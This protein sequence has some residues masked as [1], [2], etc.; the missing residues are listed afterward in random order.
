MAQFQADHS[1][2]FS[3][4]DLPSPAMKR[5]TSFANYRRGWCFGGGEEFSHKTLAAAKNVLSFMENYGLEVEVYPGEDGDIIVSGKFQNTI[6]N[7][8]IQSDLSCSFY[9]EKDGIKSAETLIPYEL[10]FAIISLQTEAW[11]TYASYTHHGIAHA[12]TNFRTARSTHPASREAAEFQWLKSNAPRRTAGMYV[13]TYP[14]FSVN[15]SVF[16]SYI[17]SGAETYCQATR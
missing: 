12:T 10:I 2:F 7:V 11:N 6:L 1:I 17:G 14:S 15:P 4:S 16:H 9:V 8:S 5:V 13:L 3:D